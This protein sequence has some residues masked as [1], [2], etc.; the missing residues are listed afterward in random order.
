MP[1]GKVVERFLDERRAAARVECLPTLIPM[2][3]QYLLAYDPA[4]DEP[5]ATPIFPAG[6]S[7]D[8]FLASPPLPRRWTPGVTLQVRGPLGH[9]FALPASARRIALVVWDVSPAYILGLIQPAHSQSASIS[10]ICDDPPEELPIDLEIRPLS[11]LGEICQWAD[12]LAVAGSR[13]SMHGWRERFTGEEQLRLPREAQALV[14][15]PMPCGGLAK[16]GVCSVD[17]RRGVELACEDG[18]VFQLHDLI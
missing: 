6:N 15:I 4:S 2:P 10:L 9:G 18:P 14:V 12:Y 11:A 1:E 16:C 7:P 13:E 3:G 5:L 17:T 8:G